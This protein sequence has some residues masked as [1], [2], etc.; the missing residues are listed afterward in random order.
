MSKPLQARPAQ[1]YQDEANADEVSMHTTRSDYEYD[2]VPELPSYSDSEAAASSSQQDDNNRR[3][4]QV[5][6]VTDP[7]TRVQPLSEWRHISHGRVQNKNKTTTRMDVRLNDPDE[8]E[9]YVLNYLQ[10]VPPNP[11]VRIVGTHQERKYDASTKKHKREK[12]TDF[13]IKFSLQHHLSREFWTASVVS[14]SEKAHR[15]SFRKTRAKG[16]KQDIELGEDATPSLQDWCRD[17]CCEKSKLKIFRVTRDVTGLETD[18][19]R[20]SIER[21]VRSTHYHGHVDISF[22]IEEKNV[23]IMTDYW[24]NKARISWIR[25]IFYLTFLWLITWP[26]LF[27]TTKRWSVYNVRWSWFR[28]HQ[29]NEQQRAWK[30]YASISEQEWVEKYKSLILGLVLE[31]Y[32]GDASA[33]PTDV[34][35]ERVQRGVRSRMSSVGNQNVDAAVTFIQGGMSVW[36]AVQGRGNRDRDAWGMDE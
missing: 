6:T 22:P 14:N 21:L 3:V 23:D 13:D 36:N 11:L 9:K 19:L 7:Y 20:A 2:D 24:V 15:G 34:S 16:Y 29:D 4:Q 17:F 32:Q 30:V 12:V 35:D 27:F 10:V 31:K 5:V 33:F 25:W 1:S 18:F 8:L 28:S 26:I